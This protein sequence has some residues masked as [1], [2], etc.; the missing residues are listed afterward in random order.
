M[1]RFVIAVINYKG[2]TGKTTS[3]VFLAHA[4]KE[5][6]IEPMLIDADPQAS[7]L[8][9]NE[10]APEPF[11]F[12]VIGLPSRELHR[13]LPDFVKPEIQAV[14]IDT[15]PLDQKSGVV[16]SALRAASVALVPMAPTPIEYKRLR[17]ARETVEDAAGFRPDGKAVPLAVLLTRTAPRA[18]ST[19]VYRE[20]VTNDG[21]W[22]LKTHVGKLER[23]AQADG[24]NVINAS[25]SAY[26]DAL[27]EIM[28]VVQ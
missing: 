2:G 3:A 14:V 18:S 15:P 27:T 26:G 13:Q 7:A 23:Y 24:D 20:Q 19:E 6:G 8:E 11:P 17:L 22:V 9:W 10:D 28:E 1:T 12:P 25:A 21:L 4:L 16:V 5:R